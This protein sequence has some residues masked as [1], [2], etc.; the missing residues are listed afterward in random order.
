MPT[1]APAAAAA[2]RPPGLPRPATGR[3]AR[4]GRAGTVSF[5]SLNHQN[6]RKNSVIIKEVLLDFIRNSE[7]SRTFNISLKN[8][9][10]SEK[11]SSES[12]QNSM[13]SV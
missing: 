1:A 4:F 2:A 13:K 7:M 8:L 3:D 12:V 11:F 9:R 5:E 6:L 10:N